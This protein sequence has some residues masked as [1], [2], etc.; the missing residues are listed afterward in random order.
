MFSCQLCPGILVDLTFASVNVF[1]FFFLNETLFPDA[2]TIPVTVAFELQWTSH[3]T[4]G[5]KTSTLLTDY[6]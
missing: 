1:F 4:G 3:Q 5:D 6:K 2:D